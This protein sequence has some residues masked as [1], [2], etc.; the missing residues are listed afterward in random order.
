MDPAVERMLEALERRPQAPAF[1]PGPARAPYGAS[2]G[3]VLAGLAITAL[4]PVAPGLAIASYGCALAALAF[5]SEA[6]LRG[7]RLR[8]E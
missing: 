3:L 2:A 1:S 6:R 5:V 8:I 4:G 7:L